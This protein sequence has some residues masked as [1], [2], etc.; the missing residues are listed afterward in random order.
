ML[1]APRVEVPD[2]EEDGA[3][4]PLVVQA[5]TASSPARAAQTRRSAFIGISWHAA[6]HALR[7]LMAADRLPPIPQ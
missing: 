6:M 7:L 5:A 4:S 1:W 2:D 3:M